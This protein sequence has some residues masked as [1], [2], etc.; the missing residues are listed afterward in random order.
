MVYGTSRD[1]AF[2]FTRRL[3]RTTAPNHCTAD[4]IEQLAKDVCPDKVNEE[5]ILY[6]PQ[7]FPSD[8]AGP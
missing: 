4:E 5:L 7:H 1:K 2:L 3:I 8:N 6:V